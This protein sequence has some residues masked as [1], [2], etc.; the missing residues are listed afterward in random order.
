M[1]I[2]ISLYVA[3]VYNHPEQYSAW[4]VI[5]AIFLFSLQIYCDFSGY[6]DI[7]RG[8]A[9]TMGY[10]LMINFNRPYFASNVREFWHRWHISLSTWFRDYVY[11]PLGGSRGTALQTI[12]ALLVVFALSGFWHGA[13]WNFIIWGL[14]HGLFVIIALLFIKK[15]KP[16]NT[17][18]GIMVTNILVA[19]TF[20]FFRTES[21][22]KAIKIIGESFHFFF[23]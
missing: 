19:Y 20:V 21:V 4:N 17:L 16:A 13:G 3:I 23:T 22:G 8:A 10:D 2:K 11:I 9:K 5:I 18:L 15:E 14:L 7:A 12:T 6:T 1:L